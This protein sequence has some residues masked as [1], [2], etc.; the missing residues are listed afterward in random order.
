[1][2]WSEVVTHIKRLMPRELTIDPQKQVSS[3]E[4]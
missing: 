2:V 4:L 3:D 1:M